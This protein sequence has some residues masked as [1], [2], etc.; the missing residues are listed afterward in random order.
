[1]VGALCLPFVFF[2]GKDKIK[3]SILI[4]RNGVQKI[5]GIRPVSYPWGDLDRAEIR[6]RRIR[7]KGTDIIVPFVKLI[8]TDTPIYADDEADTIEDSYNVDLDQLT[9][10]INQGI[11]KWGSA[12]Q[13]LA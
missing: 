13:I 11:K 12:A 9:A 7:S 6:Q 2:F 4:D 3:Q 10:L 5:I 1:M 8:R